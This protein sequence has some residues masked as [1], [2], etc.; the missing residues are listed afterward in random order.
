MTSSEAR[1]ALGGV[2][3]QYV[4]RLATEG[5]LVG[6]Q[7]A[8]GHWKLD[9]ASV[10]LVAAERSSKRERKARDAAEK[11]ALREENQD[12]FRRKREAERAA[13]AERTRA[14]DELHARGVAALESIARALSRG[15]FNAGT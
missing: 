11:L 6:E 10:E 8:H 13:E 3:Q 15:D 5:I 12:R 4:S 9:R 14:R 1:R 2:S 7:D